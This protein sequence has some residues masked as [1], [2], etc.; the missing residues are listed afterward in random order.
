MRGDLPELRGREGE[1]YGM[2]GRHFQASVHV[3]ISVPAGVL[4]KH[5]DSDLLGRTIQQDC[6]LSDPDHEHDP[7]HARQ[8]Q[9]VSFP[10]NLPD[11][12]LDRHPVPCRGVYLDLSDDISGTFAVAGSRLHPPDRHAQH[13][14]RRPGCSEHC[15]LHPGTQETVG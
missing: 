11:H 2:Q 10:S 1:L 3:L 5:P 4:L 6:V 12:L 8:F 14:L 7:V 13:R 15:L 9:Q